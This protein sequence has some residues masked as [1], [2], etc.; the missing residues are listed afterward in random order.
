MKII[1]PD[2]IDLFKISTLNTNDNENKAIE[3]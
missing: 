1:D 2:I 3:L